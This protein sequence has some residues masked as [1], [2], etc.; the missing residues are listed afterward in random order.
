MLESTRIISQ[1]F[2]MVILALVG[3]NNR[4]GCSSELVAEKI[5]HPLYV[6]E[7]FL[8]LPLSSLSRLPV[9][10]LL[11]FSVLWMAFCGRFV[12]L[13]DTSKTVLDIVS[14]VSLYRTIKKKKTLSITKKNGVSIIFR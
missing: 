8:S 4:G 2:I 14:K 7:Q 3:I 13:E 5:T 12:G 9:C 6:C 11:R 1:R 10:S